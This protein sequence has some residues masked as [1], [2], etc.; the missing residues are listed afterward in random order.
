FVN[1]DEPPMLLMQGTGDKIVG[2]KNTQ[3]LARALRAQNEPVEVKRFPDIGHFAILFAMSRPLRSKAP[4]IDDAARFI[5]AH[6][7]DTLEPN[8]PDRTRDADAASVGH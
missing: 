3:S 6:S 5:T 4:V 2:P 8:R 7:G 1:G